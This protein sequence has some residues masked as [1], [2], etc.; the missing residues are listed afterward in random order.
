[1]Q[2][3]AAPFL[4]PPM[5]PEYTEKEQQ[6]INGVMKTFDSLPGYSK[7]FI[8]F[9]GNVVGYKWE[10]DDSKK[11]EGLPKGWSKFCTWSE[12]VKRKLKWNW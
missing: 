9:N 8:F 1:M 4:F 3:V 7:Q 10:K 12:D 5:K 6:A 11:G 2:G